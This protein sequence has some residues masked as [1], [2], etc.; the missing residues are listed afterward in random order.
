ML[1]KSL[2]GRVEH[3]EGEPLYLENFLIGWKE[4]EEGELYT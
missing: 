4:P 1:R 3:K 2:R